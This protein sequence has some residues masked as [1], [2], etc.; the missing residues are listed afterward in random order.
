MP[1]DSWGSLNER[2]SKIENKKK[3][4]RTEIQEANDD[5]INPNA[6]KKPKT[7]KIQA[8]DIKSTFEKTTV[9][10]AFLKLKN[11]S[12]NPNEIHDLLTA[13]GEIGKKIAFSIGQRTYKKTVYNKIEQ[14]KRNFKGF[15]GHIKANHIE[16]EKI[17]AKQDKSYYYVKDN[18]TADQ[19]LEQIT[20]EIIDNPT[21]YEFRANNFDCSLSIIK[22][23]SSSESQK[24][25]GRDT[26]GHDYLTNKDVNSARVCINVDDIEKKAGDITWSG[27][28]LKTSF[29]AQ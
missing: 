7:A 8:I 6:E 5:D 15:I 3:R 24:I 29:P 28:E 26:I 14:G 20:K 10:I 16:S 23:F 22:D 21:K 1:I 13:G 25:F 4:A 27:G 2:F 17:K 18:S 11:T 12:I 9:T 19:L